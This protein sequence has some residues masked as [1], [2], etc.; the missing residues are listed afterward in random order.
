MQISVF[1]LLDRTCDDACFDMEQHLN[2]KVY[3]KYS[4]G[5]YKE[6]LKKH[7]ENPKT[8]ELC[9]LLCFTLRYITLLLFQ[10]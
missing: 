2:E 4:Q 10:L 9:T 6:N 5:F 1:N 8:F 7:A 3:T